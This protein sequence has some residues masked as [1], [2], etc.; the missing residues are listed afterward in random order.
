M[1]VAIL[2]TQEGDVREAISDVRA[3]P[4]RADVQRVTMTTT[5]ATIPPPPF[6]VVVAV[7][8]GLVVIP[9]RDGELAHDLVVLVGGRRGRR[10]RRE[11]DGSVDDVVDG[12]ASAHVLHIGSSFGGAER[13]KNG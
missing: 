2:P 11:D 4:E 10:R 8:L 5:G 13:K 7:V 1:R 6:L 9:A 3:R 12:E